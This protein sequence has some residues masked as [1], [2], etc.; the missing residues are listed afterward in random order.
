M[1]NEQKKNEILKNKT[2]FLHTYYTDKAKKNIVLKLKSFPNNESWLMR[3]KA[4]IEKV[5]AKWQ[6]CKKLQLTKEQQRKLSSGITLKEKDIRIVLDILFDTLATGGNIDK[7][8]NVIK[9]TENK[10]KYNPLILIFFNSWYKLID[11][12]RIANFSNKTDIME[13]LTDSKKTPLEQYEKIKKIKKFEKITDKIRTSLVWQALKIG[14]YMIVMLWIAMYTKLNLFPMMVKKF[15]EEGVLWEGMTREM[16]VWSSEKNIDIFFYVIIGLISVV[17]IMFLLYL[18]SKSTFYYIMYKIP[19]F[20]KFLN[21][22]NTIRLLMIYGGNFINPIEYRRKVF[23]LTNEYFNLKEKQDLQSV[24]TIT[25]YI[26]TTL[27]KNKWIEFFDPLASVSFEELIKG[28]AGK[29]EESTN[30]KIDLYVEKMEATQ[31]KIN[32]IIS[33][34]SLMLIGWML[35]VVMMSISLISFNIMDAFNSIQ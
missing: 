28:W 21:Y 10:I 13:I 14:W 20:K 5:K 32:G 24:G 25:E 27:R 26:E 29:V 1:A 2:F 31:V 33:N 34:L 23:E 19:W 11:L 7:V 15:V 18:F 6:D 35:I 3:E 22:L 12:L 8:Q 17:W 16:V 30:M 9:M 4:F